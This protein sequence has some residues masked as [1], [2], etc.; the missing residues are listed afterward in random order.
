MVI[1]LIWV[2]WTSFIFK[3]LGTE[4]E[5]NYDAG[6]SFGH[7][8]DYQNLVWWVA[9]MIHN[10]RNAI[11]DFQMPYYKFWSASANQNN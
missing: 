11:G 10:F 4:L 5:S 8:I 2:V 6:A 9:N 1:F 3:I 7:D